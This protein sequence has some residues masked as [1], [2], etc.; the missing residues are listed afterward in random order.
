MELDAIEN[1]TSRKELRQAIE[2]L[3]GY[4][5]CREWAADLVIAMYLIGLREKE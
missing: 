5:V 4:G 2:W 1:D 3:S